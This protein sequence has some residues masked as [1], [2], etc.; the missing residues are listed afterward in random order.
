MTASERALL[1]CFKLNRA[2]TDGARPLTG[3]S[4]GCVALLG[5]VLLSKIRLYSHQEA[6]CAKD[7]DFSRALN[8]IVCLISTMLVHALN[9]HFLPMR[10]GGNQCL[11]ATLVRRCRKR[12]FKTF[13]NER[14]KWGLEG[15]SESMNHSKLPKA[16]D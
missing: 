10:T 4:A 16:Q 15:K 13:E 11:P 12:H 7:L 9:Q 1:E 2:C 14:N 6:L 3:R 5:R 8:L